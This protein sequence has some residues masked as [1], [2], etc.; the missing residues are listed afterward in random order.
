MDA[1]ASSLMPR[2]PPDDAI[3]GKHRLQGEEELGNSGKHCSRVNG[4]AFDSSA[5]F[6]R[7][8]VSLHQYS[9]HLRLS[10]VN[11]MA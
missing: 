8:E 7:A 4:Q 11:K 10:K 6:K 1:S 9:Y 3:V 2:Q 5:A